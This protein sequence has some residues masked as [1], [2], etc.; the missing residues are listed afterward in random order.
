MLNEDLTRFTHTLSRLRQDRGGEKNALLAGFLLLVR[1]HFFTTRFSFERKAHCSL[2]FFVIYIRRE[3]M[4]FNLCDVRLLRPK[5][6]K[7]HFKKYEPKETE[8]I[9]QY[10]KAI[11]ILCYSRNVCLESPKPSSRG[12]GVRIYGKPKLESKTVFLKL[13]NPRFE[14]FTKSKSVFLEFL[15]GAPLEKI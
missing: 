12:L 6:S 11:H 5:T 3:G 9:L 15:T 2:L 14:S 8:T 10:R 7:S 4:G 13:K 1:L